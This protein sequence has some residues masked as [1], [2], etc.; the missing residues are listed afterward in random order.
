M[1]QGVLTL[2]KTVMTEQYFFGWE[3]LPG[4]RRID[5]LL[6]WETPCRSIQFVGN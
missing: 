1:L 2:I 3:L 5:S 6:F 4:V